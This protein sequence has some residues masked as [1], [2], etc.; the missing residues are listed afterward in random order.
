LRDFPQQKIPRELCGG[1]DPITHISTFPYSHVPMLLFL[2]GMNQ[3][4]FKNIRRKG[5]DQVIFLKERQRRDLE[6]KNKNKFSNCEILKNP[7]LVVFK[8][9][10]YFTQHWY[11]CIGINVPLAH[12]TFSLYYMHR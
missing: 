7:K 2:D 4:K 1:R 5:T 3:K 8:K 6:N 9:L 10:K 12:L 11:F